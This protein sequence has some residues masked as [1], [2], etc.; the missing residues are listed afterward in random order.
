MKKSFTPEE[1]A[2]IEDESYKTGRAVGLN[3]AY[4]AIQSLRNAI[5]E[6]WSIE[7][8]GIVSN[9]VQPK[10]EKLEFATNALI[11]LEEIIDSKTYEDEL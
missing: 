3:I 9:I 8:H 2:E 10:L 6:V 7:S 4:N 1:V 5:E 11:R